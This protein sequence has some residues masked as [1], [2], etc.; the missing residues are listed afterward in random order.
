MPDHM[1]QELSAEQAAR[2][3]LGRA[4][5]RDAQSFSSGDLVEVANLIALRSMIT[6][7]ALDRLTCLIDTTDDPDE[8]QKGRDFIEALRSH[9]SLGP[10]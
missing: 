8:Q 9:L 4:G 6:R 7:E 10:A 1:P 5:V 2:D 3:M